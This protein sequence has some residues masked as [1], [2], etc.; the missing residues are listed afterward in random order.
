MAKTQPNFENHK[1][2]YA[3]KKEA[4]I[5][6]GHQK[7]LLLSTWAQN[8]TYRDFS[9]RKLFRQ[10]GNDESLSYVSLCTIP[11]ISDLKRTSGMT[12]SRLKC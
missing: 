7:L 1:D 4:V 9:D 11:G 2:I 6:T 10:Q 5:L 3:L 12:E 8:V